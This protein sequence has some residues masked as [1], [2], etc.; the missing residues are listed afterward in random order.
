MHTLLFVKSYGETSSKYVKQIMYST[1]AATTWKYVLKLWDGGALPPPPVFLSFGFGVPVWRVFIIRRHLLIKAWCTL[2]YPSQAFV[3]CSKSIDFTEQI[4][5]TR[6][7]FYVSK[8]MHVHWHAMHLHWQIVTSYTFTL[9]AT[10]VYSK[11][12]DLYMKVV[13]FTCKPTSL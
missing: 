12:N 8:A 2:H 13:P 9:E 7:H 6:T 10:H 1:D 4:D 5:N 11:A 3:F